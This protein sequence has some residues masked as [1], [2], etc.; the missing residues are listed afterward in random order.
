M[1]NDCAEPQLAILVTKNCLTG[2]GLR[3]TAPEPPKPPTASRPGRFFYPLHAEGCLTSQKR[4]GEAIDKPQTHYFA[5]THLLL[6]MKAK[7]PAEM[8]PAGAI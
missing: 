3:S 1:K 6:R 4:A 7:Q 8:M 5:E 2:G